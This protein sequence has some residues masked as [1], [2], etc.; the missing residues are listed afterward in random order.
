MAESLP[1]CGTMRGPNSWRTL[2]SLRRMLKSFL[3]PGVSISLLVGDGGRLHLRLQRVLRQH[4]SAMMLDLLTNVRNTKWMNE[5]GM[6]GSS[7]PLI[8]LFSLHVTCA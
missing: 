2:S 5:S 3:G 4:A 7:P 1:F 8:T 6:W